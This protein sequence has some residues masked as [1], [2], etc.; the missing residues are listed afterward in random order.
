MAKNRKKEITPPQKKKKL[1]EAQPI[2]AT[3]PPAKSK[4]QEFIN[5]HA[6]SKQQ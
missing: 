5:K 6:V 3:E 1:K 2:A 4:W